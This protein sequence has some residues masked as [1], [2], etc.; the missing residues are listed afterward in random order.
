V[1]IL[2]EK[3]LSPDRAAKTIVACKLD[4]MTDFWN[5]THCGKQLAGQVSD[6][7]KLTIENEV[8]KLLDRFDKLITYQ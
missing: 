7:E 6:R 2:D 4:S 5:T 1:I 8:K 3:L